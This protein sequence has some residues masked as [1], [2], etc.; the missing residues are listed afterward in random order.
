[1]RAIARFAAA[2]VLAMLAG[3]GITGNFRLDPGFA[4]FSPG[5]RDTDR[6]FGLSLG[7]LPIR[8]AKA[9]TKDDPEL[10]GVLGSLKA[11]RVYIYA[12]DG[13]PR[14]V[15]R[16]IEDTRQRL[17]DRG[18]ERVVAVRDDGEF[19]TALVR[20]DSPE[21]IDGLAVM[22]QDSEQVVLINLIGNIRPETFAMLMDEI[23]VE[24][25]QTVVQL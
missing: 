1:M 16:Q 10:S 7:V 13:H 24:I 5:L 22:M 6:E 21:R 12:V 17:I 2:G 8:I 15:R 11:V 18:W 3:C 9:F 23:D 14:R 19:A 20:V 25:P 4:R